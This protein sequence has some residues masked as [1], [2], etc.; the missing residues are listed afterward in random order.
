MCE[1][2]RF[3]SHHRLLDGRFSLI[4]VVKNVMLGG[5]HS[6]MVS[7][8]PTILRPRVRILSTPFMFFSICIE[9]VTRREQK[10][11][12]RGRDWPIFKK[13]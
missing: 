6:S 4:F 13:T 7:S 3:K 9:I 1:G 5:R 12:K 8:A 11:T 10:E 2:C